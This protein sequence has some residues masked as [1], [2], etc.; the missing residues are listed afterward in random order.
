MRDTPFSKPR[1]ILRGNTGDAQGYLGEAYNL[2]FKVREIVRESGAAVFGM[3]RSFADGAVVAAAVIGTEHIVSCSAGTSVSTE[4]VIEPI[5]TTGQV[6]RLIWLP[7]GF[8]ITP[9]KNGTAPE[10]WG[11][12]DTPD[13][14]GTPDGPLRQVIINKCPN[15]N[16][17]DRMF[18]AMAPTGGMKWTLA[19]AFFK[20]YEAEPTLET[21]DG[22]VPNTWRAGIKDPRINGEDGL[23]IPAEWA[24]STDELL[25][26]LDASH[27]PQVAPLLRLRVIEPTTE[28]WHCH[29]P[30]LVRYV[31]PDAPAVLNRVDIRDAVLKEVFDE[32]N[33]ARGDMPGLF[34]PLRGWYSGIA[35]SVLFEMR[36]SRV[37][38]HDFDG[39]REGYRTF[40]ERIGRFAHPLYAAGENLITYPQS[41]VPP[42][43]TLAQAI[44]A[45]WMASPGHRANILTEWAYPD[46]PEEAGF[47]FLARGTGT[48]VASQGPPYTSPPVPIDGGV[49]GVMTTQIFYGTTDWI[50]AGNST[51]EGLAGRVSWRDP[52][53]PHRN[54]TNAAL[55]VRDFVEIGAG[56]TPI[57]VNGYLVAPAQP[58]EGELIRG[59]A[60]RYDGDGAVILVAGYVTIPSSMSIEPEVVIREWRLDD[61]FRGDAEPIS[62]YFH[63]L[64]VSTGAISK[65]IFSESGQRAVFSFYEREAMPNAYIRY[66]QSNFNTTSTL[67]NTNYG[68]SVTHVTFSD[69]TFGRGIKQSLTVTPV[70]IRTDGTR[71]FYKVQ[72]A[73]TYEA[74]KDFDG[75]TVIT[76]TIT[77]DHK[78]E[79][80]D[81]PDP[82]GDWVGQAR[83]YA[84][85]YGRIN[86]PNGE[87]F[88][89]CDTVC[90]DP[91]NLD[92]YD[93]LTGFVT[94]IGN[95]DI[96]D[97]AGI[98]Y[99]TQDLSVVFRPGSRLP[100]LSQTLYFG[101]EPV[102]LIE[103]VMPVE[104]DFTP[105]S[106]FMGF[107]NAE[108]THGQWLCNPR[109]LRAWYPSGISG[110][111]IRALWSPNAGTNAGLSS[112]QGYRGDVCKV[113]H[114]ADLVPFS[115]SLAT[116][117]APAG[118][119]H[120][121]ATFQTGPC[122][123]VAN[124]PDI[125]FNPGTGTRNYGIAEV[126]DVEHAEHD[127]ETITAVKLGVVFGLEKHGR[128]GDEQYDYR[129]T[130]D[131]ADI[132]GVDDLKKNIMPIG[133]L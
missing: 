2:L 109:P 77:V 19:P 13:N 41:A 100:A 117:L 44:V 42:G 62:T 124:G 27:A 71:N 59:A 20:A 85:A 82:A 87:Q 88:V 15:N 40:D 98:V 43:S 3:S 111:V 108:P 55:A 92:S 69:G 5:I 96:R 106:F 122:F 105:P 36:E 38:A 12:P 128:Q 113:A 116:G 64:P 95:L 90:H 80:E 129:S 1:V 86:F 26:L 115:W 66:N 91:A 65:I 31:D 58:T 74:F 103:N 125:L 130:L 110:G 63:A 97:P 9:R 33:A 6:S 29:R 120:T 7:E 47:M 48:V 68:S 11:L 133:V 14:F 10:G 123:Y 18:A 34:P 32:T 79:Q 118:A 104:D 54:A 73:G 99:V 46:V 30:Q 78:V 81:P 76:A 132:T 21:P 45:A 72:C 8:M 16:Y 131:L 22:P 4:T 51:W 93:H 107:G 56:R 126:F 57:F 114:L 52:S 50:L 83:L 102:G 89:F 84:K 94:T 35:E 37:Q 112:L 67:S 23:E 28:E 101:D 24:L 75:E 17:P 119:Q 53:G 121:L 70:D 61:C 127:G 49:T 25:A 60:L 39:Y